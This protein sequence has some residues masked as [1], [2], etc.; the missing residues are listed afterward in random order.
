M[1]GTQDY[2]IPVLFVLKIL[3]INIRKGMTFLWK[4]EMNIIIYAT[5]WSH[6]YTGKL[7]ISTY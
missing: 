4:Y 7:C 1:T 3:S 6:K 5:L 2:S